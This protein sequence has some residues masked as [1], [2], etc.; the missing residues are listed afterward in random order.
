MD[1]I[2]QSFST[3]LLA[4]EEA[5]MR[6]YATCQNYYEGIQPLRVPDKYKAIVAQAYGII[7]NYCF[8]IV[9]APVARLKID[10]ISCEDKA[11]LEALTKIW[12]YNRMD[13][14]A[15]KLHRNAIKKGDSFVQVWPHFEKGMTVPTKYEIKFLSPEVCLP[16][17][18]TDD[19]E[20]LLYVRKQWISFNEQGQ[21]VAH[22]WLF[23]PDHID[24]YYA[25]L[26]RSTMSMT[27]N[28][29]FR[30]NWVPDSTDGFPE[31]LDNPYGM[32]PI[33][34]FRNLEDESPFGTSELQNAIPVQDGINKSVINLLRT[35]DFQA[36]KQRYLL[37]VDEQ[38]IP[39]NTTTGKRELI[40]NPGDVW[41][42]SGTPQETQVG[43]LTESNSASILANINSLVDHLCAITQTPR[44]AIQDSQGTASSGFALT[45]V[46]APL[47]NKVKEKQ[48]SFGNSYEDI[49]TLLIKMMQYHG[50]LTKGEPAETSILWANLSSDSPQEKLYEAQ[51]RQILKQNKVISAKK[52]QEEEGY[53]EEEITAMQADITAESEA[54]AADLL[55]HS[56]GDVDAEGNPIEGGA[57]GEA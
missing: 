2:T 41:R 4:E 33:V 5:R 28:D 49:N 7:T 54:A 11:T 42:F 13:A 6:N 50:D 45:K 15:T 40:S 55:G 31:T 18:A 22:K 23:Y 20:S 39:V 9:E 21:P 30:T 25:P 10:G 36:F 38:E 3:W 47:I 27:V 48:T 34:H 52:W 35:D 16:I 56:F 51:R 8:P 46:E 24:R 26:S 12:K 37:G 29:Y 14:K 57:D 1:P 53:T 19:A 17:Y 43:E 44:S 32:P